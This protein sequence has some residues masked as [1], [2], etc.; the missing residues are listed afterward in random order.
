MTFK[1]TLSTLALSMLI[2]S[3]AIAN[4]VKPVPTDV[5][6]M[7]E[8]IAEVVSLTQSSNVYGRAKIKFHIDETGHLVLE[9]VHASNVELYHHIWKTVRGMEIQDT[10]VVVGQQ[11]SLTII[12]N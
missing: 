10:T 12:L 5:T 9:E 4:P 6:P 2:A 3:S 1:L 11:N 7:P 8:E